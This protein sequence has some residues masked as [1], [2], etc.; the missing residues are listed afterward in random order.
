MPLPPEQSHLRPS[1]PDD[2]LLRVRLKLVAPEAGGRRHGLFTEYHASWH[3]GLDNEGPL[4]VHDAPV[5]SMEPESISAG[6]EATLTIRPIAPEFWTTIGPGREIE[7]REGARTVGHG[8]VITH[9]A[10]A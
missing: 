1:G 6:G 5:V 4:D 7:M 3:L 10:P 8:L 2:V 9:R